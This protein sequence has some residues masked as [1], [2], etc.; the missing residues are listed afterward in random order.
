[1]SISLVFSLTLKMRYILQEFLN[2]LADKLTGSELQAD[3]LNRWY[4]RTIEGAAA[5]TIR[6][7][8]MKLLLSTWDW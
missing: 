1:M 8:C 2:F 4:M 7:H 5:A 3:S 6:A